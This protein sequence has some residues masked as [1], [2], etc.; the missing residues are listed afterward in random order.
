MRIEII[1][2]NE[3]K[4][5][6]V[7]NDRVFHNDEEFFSLEGLRVKNTKTREVY[8]GWDQPILKQV[9]FDGGILGLLR[10]RFNGIPHYL[11][12]AKAEPGNPNFVQI[13]F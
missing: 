6:T 8:F 13:D 3:C 5:W 9:G 11:V 7:N 2:L 1:P 12:E 10:K 4:D